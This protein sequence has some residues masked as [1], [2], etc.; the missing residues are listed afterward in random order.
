MQLIVLTFYNC[1]PATFSLANLAIFIILNKTKYNIADPKLSPV[2]IS[3]VDHQ[4]GSNGADSLRK[5]SADNSLGSKTK[6]IL[7]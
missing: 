5:M 1:F 3:V 4:S 2:L 6:A 7:T